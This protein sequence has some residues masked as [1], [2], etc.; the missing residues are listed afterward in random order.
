MKG[1]RKG[2]GGP[3]RA[4]PPARIQPKPAVA[5]FGAGSPGRSRRR[6]LLVCLVVAL[7]GAGGLAFHLFT[8]EKAAPEPAAPASAPIR[9]WQVDHLLTTVSLPTGSG[10]TD[11]VTVGAHLT[12]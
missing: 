10:W 8:P 5:P 7:G 3:A 9:D 4:A 2:G 6:L 12:N 1:R 11:L